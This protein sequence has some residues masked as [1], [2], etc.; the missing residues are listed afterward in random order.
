M[1]LPLVLL[2]GGRGMLGA[3]IQRANDRAGSPLT[4]IAPPRSEL[5]LND[6]AEVDTY[7]KKVKPDLIIHAA[8]KV[9]GIA[10]NI[11]DPSA[12]LADNIRI[13]LAVIGAAFANDVPQLLNIGSS[14]MYP[15]DHRQPLVEDDVLTAALEPTNEGYA[16]A[17]IVAARHCSY[18]SS[19]YPL[20][21]RT[22][23]PCNLY[24]PG[25]TYEPNLSHL[26]ASVIAKVHAAKMAQGKTVE[27][28]GDG[29][30]R[31]EFLYVDD[32]ADW[33]VT[34]ATNG[35]GGLPQLLNL[36]AGEDHSV[37]E[38][39]R[40]A[41]EVVGYSGDFIFDPSKPVG[42]KQKLM[43][44]TTATLRHDWVPGTSLQTGIANAYEDFLDRMPVNV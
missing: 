32:L 2:T 12:F 10:A 42:M 15:K 8:A 38:Y 33:I 7:V 30:A 16:L 24:G 41:A 21:Y 3:A 43:D 44:S 5:D 1:T 31:R 34:N 4:L 28:W 20:S 22:I 25:D 29:T 9:G 37:E 23:I 19:S 35:V 18:L 39:Y 6:G 13:N 11:A 40:R 14:C 36:G 26:V 27:I 17:K